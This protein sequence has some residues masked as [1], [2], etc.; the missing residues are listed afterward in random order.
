MRCG[1]CESKIPDKIPKGRARRQAIR[2]GRPA[3]NQWSVGP[4]RVIS[5]DCVVSR[6]CDSGATAARD[7][8]RPRL[9]VRRRLDPDV[10]PRHHARGHRRR[11]LRP[12]RRERAAHLGG[13]V[14]DGPAARLPRSVSDPGRRGPADDLP[15]PDGVRP[16][17]DPYLVTHVGGGRGVPRR[18][19]QRRRARGRA[20]RDR[21]V[22]DVHLCRRLLRVV[23]AGALCTARDDRRDRDVRADGRARRRAEGPVRAAARGRDA[24]D[25]IVRS[26]GRGC[27]RRDDD[28][29]VRRV[30]DH[31]AR[32]GRLRAAVRGRPVVEAVADDD[33]PRRDRERAAR[34]RRE[35]RRARSREATVAR[36]A[37]AVR[38][39]PR[40]ASDL[41]MR[42]CCE[43]HATTLPR[44]RSGASRRTSRPSRPAR[45]RGSPA[46][47]WPTLLV[48]RVH[49][50]LE[51]VQFLPQTILLVQWW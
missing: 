48:L 44:A 7:A 20:G 35:A 27:W 46:R 14:G 31:D 17:V 9:R 22:V 11:R 6:P 30:R 23:D 40:P 34:G 12:D 16:A 36:E 51:G 26:A 5:T 24:P 28:G 42:C 38:V 19:R 33:V 29:V 43:G 47:S 18:E 4:R 25:A 39:S 8:D 13:E 2:S 32:L 15:I 49:L 45:A 21:G 3:I 41:P 37:A 10:I 1:V 50:M